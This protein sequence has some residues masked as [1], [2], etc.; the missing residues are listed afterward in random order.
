MGFDLMVFDLMGFDL[1]D[2]ILWEYTEICIAI[3]FFQVHENEVHYEM[4]MKCVVIINP[5]ESL[6]SHHHEESLS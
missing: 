5:N 6:S 4:S 3:Q 1:F 2:S